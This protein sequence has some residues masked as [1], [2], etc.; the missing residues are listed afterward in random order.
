MDEEM[1]K[2]KNEARIKEV[3]NIEKGTNKDKLE[4]KK[5]D[6]EEKRNK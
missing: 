4:L 3:I 1:K 6:K 5:E 2:Q